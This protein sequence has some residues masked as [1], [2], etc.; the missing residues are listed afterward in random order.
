MIFIL[1][2]F[3]F[4]FRKKKGGK[5]INNIALLDYCNYSKLKEEKINKK[6]KLINK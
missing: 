1:L 6:K 2:F 4:L 3:F 5:N